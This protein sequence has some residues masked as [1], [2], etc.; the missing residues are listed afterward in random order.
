MNKSNIKRHLHFERSKTSGSGWLPGSHSSSSS[1]NCLSDDLWDK[2]GWYW[3]LSSISSK[4]PTVPHTQHKKNK[5]SF[6]KS[7]T[8]PDYCNAQPLPPI[9]PRVSLFIRHFGWGRQTQSRPPSSLAFLNNYFTHSQT[10]IKG[11]PPVSPE[12]LCVE[13]NSRG[14]RGP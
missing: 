10:A 8:W 14:A 12:F 3:Q 2:H 7:W 5:K 1:W 9:H 6:S 13:L 11:H 4:N